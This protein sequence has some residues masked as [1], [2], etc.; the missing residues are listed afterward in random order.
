MLH[1]TLTFRRG[2]ILPAAVTVRVIVVFS[3][4]ATCTINGGGGVGRRPFMVHK[5][6][7]AITTN[8]KI[9]RK[10]LMT[11]P[12]WRRSGPSPLHRE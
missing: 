10:M 3:A 9:Q 7:P 11:V 8:A 4:L 1:E 12:R 5:P 2:S 6:T